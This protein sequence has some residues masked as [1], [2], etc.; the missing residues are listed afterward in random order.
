MKHTVLEC[1]KEELVRKYTIIIIVLSAI[2]Y[3]TIVD[4]FSC[5]LDA[6]HYVRIFS[7]INR[8]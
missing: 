1:I 7:F 5:M 2:F 4:H 8:C 3:I 6:M